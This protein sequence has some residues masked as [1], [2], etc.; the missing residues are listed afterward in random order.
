[1]LFY[2][3]VQLFVLI[4]YLVVFLLLVQCSSTTFISANYTKF[5]SST[6]ILSAMTIV[7]GI[8]VQFNGVLVVSVYIRR[9][10][11]KSSRVYLMMLPFAFIYRNFFLRLCLS[12]FL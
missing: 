12:T 7:V 4:D 3:Q 10:P 6:D 1:M 9:T 5:G 11:K 8:T 2:L